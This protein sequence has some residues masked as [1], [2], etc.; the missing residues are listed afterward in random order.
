MVEK[1]GKKGLPAEKT[2][3]LEPVGHFSM[4]CVTSKSLQVR[5]ATTPNNFE[6]PKA[7]GDPLEPAGTT[8]AGSH[9]HTILRNYALPPPKNTRAKEGGR[10]LCVLCDVIGSNKYDTALAND[11]EV[12]GASVSL[13]GAADPAAHV[14]S[15]TRPRY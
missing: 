15:R 4:P 6:V 9:I 13:L 10:V 14:A 3:K 1:G 8:T 12:M 2:H 7:V 5:C 11:M